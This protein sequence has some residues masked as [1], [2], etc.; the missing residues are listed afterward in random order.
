M[1]M[2]ISINFWSPE[3]NTRMIMEWKNLETRRKECLVLSW[4]EEKN[5]D[6][7]VEDDPDISK[8]DTDWR[9]RLFG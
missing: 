9:E 4:A 1:D 6:P 2:F 5:Q 7:D 3:E 8:E